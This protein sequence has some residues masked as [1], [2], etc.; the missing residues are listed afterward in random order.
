M[1]IHYYIDPE[2][3]QPHIYTHHVSEDEVE[4]VLLKPGEDRSGKDGSRVA[5]GQSRAGRYLKVIY[6]ID[7]DPKS[8]F[9]I[10]AFDLTGKPLIAYKRRSRK[11]YEKM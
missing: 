6:V 5:I 2:N 10:T 7:F 9:V 4:D 8:I 3:G 11:K 1:N